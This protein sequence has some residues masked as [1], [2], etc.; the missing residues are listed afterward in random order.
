M[1][2]AKG[3]SM[4]TVTGHSSL[5]VKDA[6]ASDEGQVT[7]D[8]SPRAMDAL[9]RGIRCGQIGCYAKT[10]QELIDAGLARMSDAGDVYP[11]AAGLEQSSL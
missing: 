1:K 5:G 2:K 4:D 9:R 10:S 7:N 6:G 11:T 3:K 8:I